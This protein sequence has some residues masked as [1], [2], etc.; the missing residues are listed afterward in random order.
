MLRLTED[1]ITEL[2][3]KYGIRL[4]YTERWAAESL[5][6]EYTE[7]IFKYEL[8]KLRITAEAKAHK[9]QVKLNKVNNDT[10]EFYNYTEELRYLNREISIIEDNLKK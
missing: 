5:K 10:E 7:V 6:D 4:S 9:I 3:L 1:R 2:E 8:N